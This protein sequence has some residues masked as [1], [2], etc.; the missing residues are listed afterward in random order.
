MTKRPVLLVLLAGY[1]AILGWVTLTPRSAASGGQGPRWLPFVEIWD[2][3]VSEG[4]YRTLVQVG[5]NIALFIPLGGLLPMVWPTL[6]SRKRIL[7]VAAACSISIELVQLI[8]PGRSMAA[9]DV[10]LNTVGA[11]IGAT[12]LFGARVMPSG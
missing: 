12:L 8:I 11:F 1:G 4:T 6:R 3:F 10:I 9:S 5:G 7:L 2:A